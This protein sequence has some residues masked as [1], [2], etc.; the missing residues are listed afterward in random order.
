ME[1][2]KISLEWTPFALGCLDE[3][4]D[5]ITYQEKSIQ[6]ANIL[7]NRIFDRV[8]QPTEFPESGQKEPLLKELDSRYLVEGSYKIIYEYHQK[9]RLVVITD[10]FHTKQYPAKIKRTSK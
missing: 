8:E 7:I 10:V 4:H 9:S 3:I 5:Y 2:S 6:P 1:G